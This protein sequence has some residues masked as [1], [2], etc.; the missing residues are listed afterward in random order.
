MSLR[1]P[2]LLSGLLALCLSAT[3]ALAQVPQMD[4]QRTRISAGMY[5]ID[6]Q[7]ALTPQQQQTGLMYR[8]E[9]P[10][11]EGMLFVFEQPSTQCFWMKNTLLPLS[12]AF[13][14]DDGRI[15]NLVDMQPLTLDSHCSEEPVRYVLE[16]N[17]GWFAKKNIKKGAKLTGAP[18]QARR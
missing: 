9:M 6:A 4:L 14:A 16:M 17:Q 2:A 10:Q 1:L 7:V 11:A 12:A 13:V 3:A 15:V 8:K 18:F 5:Q